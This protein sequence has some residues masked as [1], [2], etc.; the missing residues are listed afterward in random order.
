MRD[1]E[2]A[3]ARGMKRRRNARRA[4]PIGIGLHHPSDR[5]RCRSS[6]Q[7]APIRR[8]GRKVNM[9]NRGR[10]HHVEAGSAREAIIMLRI[11]IPKAREFGFE[12]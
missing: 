3:A 9:Q 12:E 7:R 8:N 4:K 1:K 6:S 10:V 2:M 5:P 11:Q